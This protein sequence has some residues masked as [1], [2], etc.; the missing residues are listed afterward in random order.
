MTSKI[1]R[2]TLLCSTSQIGAAPRHPKAQ[3]W[4]C[5]TSVSIVADRLRLQVLEALHRD[6]LAQREHLLL[7]LLVLVAL[8]REPHADAPR[9]EPDA[10][11]PDKLVQLRVHP[12][13]LRA[14][15]LRCE[16]LDRPDA[17]LGAFLVLHAKNIL[18]EVDREVTS[19]RLHG[20]APGLLALLAHV[21]ET[22]LRMLRRSN[23][24][25]A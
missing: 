12:H 25:G 18:L 23:H 20:L 19:H 13:I 2:A 6:V 16:L 10:A 9:H 24:T 22:L 3:P 8:A 7:G 14:H 1:V 17:S 15:G 11:A 4:A 21:H 5:R